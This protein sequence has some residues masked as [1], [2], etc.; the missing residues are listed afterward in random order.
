MKEIKKAIE[1]WMKK[2]KGDVALLCSFVSFDKN[3][4]VKD[5]SLVF[6]Y[7]YKPTIKVIL[8]DMNENVKKEKEDF[9]NW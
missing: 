7:G 4:D 8:D 1:K 5:D 2:N 3:G 9:I 6:G